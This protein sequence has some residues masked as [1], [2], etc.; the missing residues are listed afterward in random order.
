M[1]AAA[2][3]PRSPRCRGATEALAVVAVGA[4]LDMAAVSGPVEPPLQL[5]TSASTA[6][7]A[8]VAAGILIFVNM[9]FSFGDGCT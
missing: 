4:L 5:A 2:S 1:N 3:L 9:V 6:P 7:A 8:A